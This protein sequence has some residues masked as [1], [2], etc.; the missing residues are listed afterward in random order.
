L[1]QARDLLRSRLSRRGVALTPVLLAGLLTPAVAS[2]ALTEVTLNAATVFATGKAA[3]GVSAQAGALAEGALHAMFITKVKSAAAIVAALGL[4]GG[5]AGVAWHQTQTTPHR[6]DAVPQH[7][8]MIDE[9][10]YAASPD[11]PA[12]TTVYSAG[13]ANGANP[14]AGSSR[15]DAQVQRET[16]RSRPD[17]YSQ[18]VEAEKQEA[19]RQ[20][21]E[22]EAQANPAPV[23]VAEAKPDDPLANPP[24]SRWWD[25]L[26]LPW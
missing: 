21:R 9:A 1:T 22:A 18:L 14:K 17:H 20:R 6:P 7:V 19:E 2:A 15:Q 11:F 26:W 4:V 12:T 16:P 13:D 25:W 23:P 24:A 3:I 10:D 8:T 5:G